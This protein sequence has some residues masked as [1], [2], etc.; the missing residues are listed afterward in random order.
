[1]TP[2]LRPY[3]VK[4]VEVA[5]REIVAGRRAVL[6]VSPTG[7]GKTVLA[8]E[9]I[10]SAN[11]RGSR[12]LFLAHR[13]ELIHQTRDKLRSFGVE[14]GIIMAGEPMALSAPCQ[15]AS[16]Q[17]LAQRRDVLTRVDLIFFDEAHHAAAKTYTDAAKLF[18]DAKVV[19]LTATP[20][21]SDGKGLAD[22][23]DSHVVVATPAELR[24]GGYLCPVGGWEFRSIAM[25]DAQV[26]G[27][28]FVQSSMSEAGRDVKLLGSIVGEYV[29]RANGRPGIC[30]CVSVAAS[31]STA[32]AFREAG[33]AAEHL[34]GETPR[35][36][37]DAIL[38]RLR[39]GETKMVTNCAVLTEGFDFPS[40]EVCI[41]A[42]PTLSPG[43]YLQRVGRVLRPAPG[44][45][46]AI[47][48]DH[49]KSLATH[50][51]PYEERDYA[52]CEADPERSVNKRRKDI[53]SKVKTC[54]SCGSV[55]F[56]WPCPSCGHRPPESEVA[57]ELRVEAV[58]IRE[59][60][61]DAETAE[62]AAKFAAMS[63]EERRAM[64]GR[65][66]AKHGSETNKALGI[67]R[68]ASGDT[69]WPRREWKLELGFVVKS[70]SGGRR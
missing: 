24:D 17:T 55:R 25:D 3:Q 63:D 43:L 5:R 9:I 27:G 31:E 38:A 6:L 21:R 15:V 61:K 32:L 16:I 2:V 35:E 13:R 29:A 68:W 41:L 36:E 1:M 54:P 14:P 58:E 26:R 7:S 64:F 52:P 44:K 10:R 30:F 50:G 70:W 20:W 48:H 42:S 4:A 45:E 67:Y 46:R 62:R 22:I 33:V 53:E 59:R 39:S 37:R 34:D 23:F 28:D 11:A 47:I 19:G 56:G 60:Q 57:E 40:L 18:P 12:T 69:A 49:C 51:H 66:V 8:S 65:I